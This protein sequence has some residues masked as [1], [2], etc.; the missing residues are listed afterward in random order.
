MYFAIGMLHDLQ[1]KNCK[2]VVCIPS[3]KIVISGDKPNGK[4]NVLFI[5]NHQSTS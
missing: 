4:E 1:S 3:Q 5:S 2:H